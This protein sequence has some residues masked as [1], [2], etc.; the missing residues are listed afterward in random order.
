MA[1]NRA[2]TS[3]EL[4][5]MQPRFHFWLIVILG[6]A[7]A[8]S[9]FFS[10]NDRGL[11]L[12]DRPSAFAVQ[13]PAIAPEL[14][15]TGFGAGVL[16]GNE[17]RGARRAIPPRGLPPAAEMSAQEDTGGILGGSSA[18]PPVSMFTPPAGPLSEQ[19]VRLQISPARNATAVSLPGVGDGNFG[20]TPL[21]LIATTTPIVDLSDGNPGNGG[22]IPADPIIPAI[23]EP[24]S[25]LMMIMA[26]FALGLMLRRQQNV[27][28]AAT[29]ELNRVLIH[30][31]R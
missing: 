22:G 20:S 29:R 18:G 1:S 23:P 13:K 16:H 25:W 15:L 11:L 4:A 21:G 31:G 14:L 7:L 12:Y 8:A 3:A 10:T 17:L 30:T 24:A 28:A 26:V 6:A 9:A 19:P 5:A 27:T 2:T